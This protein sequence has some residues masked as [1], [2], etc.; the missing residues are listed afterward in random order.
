MKV[1]TPEGRKP[2]TTFVLTKFYTTYTYVEGSLT[3]GPYF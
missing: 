1:D 3:H 2:K